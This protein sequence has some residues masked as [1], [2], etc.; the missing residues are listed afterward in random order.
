[1][2]RL[3]E[4]IG[5]VRDVELIDLDELY[6]YEGEHGRVVVVSR[7]LDRTGRKLSP[8]DAPPLRELLGAARKMVGADTMADVPLRETMGLLTSV[9]LLPRMWPSLRRSG[10]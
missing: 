7:D 4:E 6:H 5:L 1:M 10:S 3:S 2:Y 8:G 9:S